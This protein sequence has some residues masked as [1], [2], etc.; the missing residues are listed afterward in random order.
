MDLN[1]KCPW[2]GSVISREKFVQIE[3]QIR[4]QERQ[5]LREAE[6][7][8]RKE[9]VAQFS[10]DLEAAKRSAAQKLEEEANKRIAEAAA[11]RDETLE[12]LGQLQAR[13]AEAQRQ[14]QE[15]NESAAKLKKDLE[16]Q[17]ESEKQAAQARGKEEAQKEF[18][19]LRTQVTAERE[20]T[21]EQLRQ[22]QA[23]EAE[24]QRQ[25]QEA[26][27]SAARAKKNL[28][29]QLES[30]KQAAQ[31]RG[32]EEAQ[33]EYAEL[34]TQVTA[35]REKAVEQLRLVRVSEAEAKRQAQ[36]ATD[37]VAA[38]K[39][40][41]E[42][43]L[44]AER[45]AAEKR[46]KEE[47]EAMLKHEMERQRIILEQTHDADLS[48]QKSEFQK[49]NEAALKE[50][51]ELKHR[52]EQQKTAN[53]LGDGAEVDLYE[54]LRQEFPGDK[55]SRVQK[56]QAGPDI[57]H[58][59]IYKGET[60]GQIVYD[61]KNHLKW[62][63]QWTS[64]L[65]QDQ[66]NAGA[67]HAILATTVFPT[68]KKEICVDDSGVILVNPARAVHIAH[69]LRA[70]I[71]E[72]HKKGLG[73]MERAGKTNR[74]YEFIASNEYRQQFD[75][76]QRLTDELLDLDVDEKKAHDKVWKERGQ[77]LRKQ[78]HALSEI[79]TKVAAIIE[80]PSAGQSS[81]A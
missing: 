9:L 34:R 58:W 66:I 14:A 81:A 12:R 64:K 57:R 19:E 27:E 4:E 75:Q 69:L 30:E 28:E 44:E 38:L 41:F 55:I 47:T 77:R 1:E 74:L 80:A 22:V 13:E 46:A 53:Q 15:A 29:Q 5:K 78:Q 18:A 31:E 79:D 51:Q 40:N 24:A 72:M 16:Q 68:G 63:S 62:M 56:G 37:S 23:R 52:L 67:E 25:A 65:H 70:A 36:Q 35:E 45:Q 17:L 20:K 43:Q 32:R 60:C 26:I 33:K 61:S 42:H 7:S 39:K 21:L 76:V 11:E 2:C 10:Q 50:V 48:K 71:I 8:M 6:D 54:S 73:Q 59:V 49:Q 3:G